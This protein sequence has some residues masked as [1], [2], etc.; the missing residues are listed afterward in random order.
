[1]N[2]K[3]WIII[4]LIVLAIDL[5][6]VYTGNENLRYITK[7][8]LIPLLIVYFGFN[9]KSFTSSLKKWVV[10]AL[11]FSW[12]GDILLMFES[13]NTNFFIFGLVA[14]LIAHI[15]YIVLFD[16][17]RVKEKF[18]QSLLPL[19]PI[20]I[21]YI[22]LMSLLQPHLG[23][24]QKPVAIYGLIISTMLSFAIDL[25]RV[26]DRTISF[27]IIPGAVLFITSDSLL[28]LNKFYKQFE[29][30]G[31]AVMITY[32]IAQLLITI[33]AVKY[34]IRHQKNKFEDGMPREQGEM[35]NRITGV[36][37]SVASEV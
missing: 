13:T 6:V 35:K 21:Y 36:E 11:S 17:I 16:H 22:L 1:M 18:R 25:R 28:A 30:A 15:F 32:G 19:I 9:T 24:M 34:I 29:Y 2:K 27:L 7:P 10:L 8:L 4:Y 3:F 31:V 5:Y 33:G 37:R 12:A 14:F 23:S 26:K 20:A